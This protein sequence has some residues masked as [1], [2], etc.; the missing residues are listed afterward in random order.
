MADALAV[1]RSLD[2]ANKPQQFAVLTQGRYITQQ[3][4]QKTLDLSLLQ[5]IYLH[6]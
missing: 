5:Q 1:I 3:E 2:S 4:L 6:S